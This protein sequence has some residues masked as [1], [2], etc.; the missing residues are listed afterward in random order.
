MWQQAAKEY[1][2]IISKCNN[3]KQL[4]CA[5]KSKSEVK[6]K[7]LHSIEPVKISLLTFFRLKW[8]YRTFEVHNS[9]TENEIQVVWKIVKEI[10]PT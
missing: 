2:A 9:A 6:E 10:D 8:N 4:R 7:S 1:E 5:A 3:M